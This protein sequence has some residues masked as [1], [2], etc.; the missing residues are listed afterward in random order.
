MA[1]IDP[2]QFGELRAKVE[3]QGREIGELKDTIAGMASDVKDL[4][5]LANKGKGGLWFGMGLVSIA[6]A[7]VGWVLEH[8]VNK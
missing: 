1:D 5:A 6:S 4:L 3:A 8:T 2:I 7:A